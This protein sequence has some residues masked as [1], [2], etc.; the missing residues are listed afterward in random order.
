MFVSRNQAAAKA[1]TN[2][3][4]FARWVDR[5]LIAPNEDGEYELSEAIKVGRAEGTL[6]AQGTEEAATSSALEIAMAVNKSLMAHQEKMFD[7]YINAIGSVIG[8]LSSQLDSANS[9]LGTMSTESVEMMGAL[10]E[11]LMA[12]SEREAAMIVARQKSEALKN[13]GETLVHNVPRLFGQQPAIVSTLQRFAGSLSEDEKTALGMMS[14][15]FEEP[16]KRAD[17]EQILAGLGIVKTAT[18]E[19]PS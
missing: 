5:G 6:P 19:Q 7:K 18:Q 3:R 14:E 4:T 10:R 15:A 12:G 9:R 17:F 2:T 13:L 11:I 1:G 8:G 16:E